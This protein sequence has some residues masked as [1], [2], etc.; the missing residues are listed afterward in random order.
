MGRKV[1]DRI[2]LTCAHCAQGFSIPGSKAIAYPS[3]KNSVTRYCSAK[4]YNLAKTKP[5]PMFNCEHCGKETAYKKN[6]KANG[7]LGSYNYKQ[8]FCSQS[9]AA[10]AQKRVSKGFADK[11]GYRVIYA[12][13]MQEF[14]HRLV[15]EKVLGRKLILGE[16]VH[17]KDGNRQNNNPANLELW[18]KVQPAGQRVEDKIV[19][20][21]KLLQQYPDLARSQGFAL[22]NMNVG[23]S[24][25]IRA[26][27]PNLR[28]VA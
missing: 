12:N 25:V 28:L 14:E 21:I 2:A 7:N 13:G 24:E 23:V 27:K 15:M 9:C 6:L 20:A 5:T 10:K 16:S 8:R 17:H 4:C 11:N 1:L 19:W 18:S 3:R 26:M 22:V